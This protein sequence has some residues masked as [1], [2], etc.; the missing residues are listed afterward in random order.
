MIDCSK[1]VEIAEQ[2]LAE[3]DMFVVECTCNNAN[4]VELIIDSDTSVAID[5]CVDLSRAINEQFDRDVEDFSLMVASA[6]IGSPLKVY[7]QYQKLIGR[8]VEV[9]LA[10]GTKILA[11]MTEAT[12][13]SITL[14]YE[15][16][17]AVEGKKRKQLVTVVNSYPLTEVKWTKE[18]LD[19]K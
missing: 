11:T 5:V 14:S 7:R 8:P 19:Y 6:G 1:I 17:Q 15:E 13:E 10:C 9:L 2:L 3:S 4:E 12:P 16:K 18:Y